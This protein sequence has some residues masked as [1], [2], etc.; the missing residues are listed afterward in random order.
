MYGTI[1]LIR[2]PL[3]IRKSGMDYQATDTADLQVPELSQKVVL[4]RIDE[5]E[6][7]IRA[8]EAEGKATEHL[9]AR[10]A[11][12]DERLNELIKQQTLLCMCLFGRL[13]VPFGLFADNSSFCY[14]A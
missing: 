3:K 4:Q 10:L 9:Y 13:V 1:R 2:R 12:L 11:P 6:K 5:V 14:L 7:T 8:A